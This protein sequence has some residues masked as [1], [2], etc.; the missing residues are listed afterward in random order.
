MKK[1][2]IFIGASLVLCGCG[3]IAIGIM[4]ASPGTPNLEATPAPN[5]TPSGDA[6]EPEVTCDSVPDDVDGVLALTGDQ[7]TDLGS[8]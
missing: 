4:P 1:S 5:D 8:D 7:S 2:Y 3:M 6:V